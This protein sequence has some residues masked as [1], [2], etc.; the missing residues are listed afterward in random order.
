M[1]PPKPGLLAPDLAPFL[2]EH[3]HGAVRPGPPCRGRPQRAA[4]AQDPGAPR[5]GRPRRDRRAHPR[6]HP[7][8]TP[9]ASAAAASEPHPTRF[10]GG[11]VRAPPHARPRQ[12][13]SSSRARPPAHMVLAEG[14]VGRAMSGQDNRERA[15][16]GHPPPKDTH[17]QPG[18]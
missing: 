15:L 16:A 2:A 7:S 18:P 5:R 9:P 4:C 1:P 8:P 3:P 10:R 11:R 6:P 12:R 13:P 17:G 14:S